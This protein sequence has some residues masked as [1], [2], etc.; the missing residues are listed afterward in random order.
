MAK[1]KAEQKNEHTHRECKNVVP[2]M[3]NLSINDKNPILG[4]CPNQQHKILL[5]YP[6][7]KN[8][9]KK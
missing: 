2:D 9:V 6:T 1:K 7:C 3:S 5:S 4:T 8:F